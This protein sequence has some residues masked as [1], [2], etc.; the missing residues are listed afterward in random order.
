MKFNKVIPVIFLASALA[1]SLSSCKKDDKTT[2]PNNEASLTIT[3]MQDDG[4]G[5]LTPIEDAI[6][7]GVFTN[8]GDGFDILKDIAKAD[9]KTD[10]KGQYV[11][12][13]LLIGDY[14]VGVDLNDDGNADGWEGVLVFP[15]ENE[16]SVVID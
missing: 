13:K 11:I 6:I 4:M 1:I 9:K 12:D 2:T 5:N 16:V 8:G 15:G 10:D 7:L 3:V 14:F